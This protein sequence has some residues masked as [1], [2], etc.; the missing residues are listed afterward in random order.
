MAED[1]LL[2]LHQLLS[3][4]GLYTPGRLPDYLLV[5]PFYM[6]KSER[7]A[8]GGKNRKYRARNFRALISE[9]INE[10]YQLY[11]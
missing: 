6:S 3:A 7:A 9:Y 5:S 1:A 10:I 8:A 2:E 11:K 4:I